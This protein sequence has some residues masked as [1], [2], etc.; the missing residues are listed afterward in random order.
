MNNTKNEAQR[1][2]GGGFPSSDIWPYITLSSHLLIDVWKSLQTAV[3]RELWPQS[4]SSDTATGGANMASS[5][6]SSMLTVPSATIP[7]VAPLL[8]ENKKKTQVCW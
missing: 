4:P 3:T 2:Y 8:H 6:L 7:S 5:F 1:Q